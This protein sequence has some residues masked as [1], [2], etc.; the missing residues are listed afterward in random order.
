MN[1]IISLLLQLVCSMI[2]TLFVV[3]I[4]DRLMFV[5][6]NSVILGMLIALLIIVLDRVW[7]IMSN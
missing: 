1:K 4:A 5:D 3:L 2:I 7:K 6:T